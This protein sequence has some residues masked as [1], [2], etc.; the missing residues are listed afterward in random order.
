MHDILDPNAAV[1][2]EYI[3]H[4][5]ET[6]EG[7]VHMGI[8]DSETDEYIVIKKMGGAKVTINKADIK[9]LSSMGTSLMMEG[10][11]GAMS[12]QDMADLLAFLRHT[13]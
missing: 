13:E 8:V 5:V 7:E 10:L 6:K 1:N 3:N 4:K 11:E 2:T 9:N 12:I